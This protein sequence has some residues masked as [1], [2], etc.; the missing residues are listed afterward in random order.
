MEKAL[1]LMEKYVG[2]H[3]PSLT[4]HIMPA[5]RGMHRVVPM[6]KEDLDFLDLLFDKL[7]QILSLTHGPDHKLIQELANFVA[8]VRAESPVRRLDR[9][10][11]HMSGMMLAPDD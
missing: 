4:G 7:K 11:L 1:P 10:R 6:S 9:H 2:P 5:V 3:H 8:V